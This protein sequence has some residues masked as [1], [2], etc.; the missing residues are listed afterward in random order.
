MW[1]VYA[2]YNFTINNWELTIK[3]CKLIV[4]LIL[5]TIFKYA[6]VYVWLHTYKYT[7][8]FFS[9]TI[10]FLVKNFEMS[11]FD[12]INYNFD[13]Q[14]LQMDYQ[15]SVRDHQTNAYSYGAIC[16]LKNWIL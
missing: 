12:I 9:L 14:S 4:K 5:I 6:I 1:H 10:I 3:H 2:M 15:T 7:S 13:Y 8:C 11:F 16:S